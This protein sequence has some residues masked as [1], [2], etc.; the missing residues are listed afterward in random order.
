MGNS[1]HSMPRTREAGHLAHRGR[2]AVAVVRAAAHRTTIRSRRSAR[3]RASST[4]GSTPGRAASPA[5]GRGTRRREMFRAG[6]EPGGKREV[7]QAGLLYSQAC[8]SW[9]VDPLKA[10]L[11]PAELERRRPGLGRPGPARRRGHGAARLAHRVLLGPQRLGRPARG[12]VLRPEARRSARTRATTRART[13][14]R[15]R[16]R[17]TTSRR[18]RPSPSRPIR[19]RLRSARCAASFVSWAARGAGL[20]LG[21]GLVCAA[22]AGSRRRR[23]TSCC[24][25]SSPSCSPRRSN[26]SSAGCGRARRSPAGR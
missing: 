14:T 13:R 20:A 23:S 19:P 1:D 3:R 15:S 9:A 6:T 5:R 22:R 2:P 10:E 21:V 4:S 24:S 7:D 11:G 25:R 8:G 18:T 26:R 17:A 12:A 16:A